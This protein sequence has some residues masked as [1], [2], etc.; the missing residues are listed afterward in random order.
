M[1][2]LFLEKTYGR[3]SHVGICDSRCE[4]VRSWDVLLRTLIILI[5]LLVMCD[6]MDSLIVTSSQILTIVG[7][8]IVQIV[9]ILHKTTKWRV[10]LIREEICLILMIRK[11]RWI[12]RRSRMKNIGNLII[13]RCLKCGKNWIG[14]L[15]L[16][17]LWSKY[18]SRRFIHIDHLHKTCHRFVQSLLER[19]NDRLKCLI[20]LLL[21]LLFDRLNWQRFIFV[22]NR[23]NL[24]YRSRS[25]WLKELDFFLFW[26]YINRDI[27]RGHFLILSRWSCFCTVFILIFYVG[28]GQFLLFCLINFCGF[29]RT[30]SKFNLLLE[31]DPSRTICFFLYR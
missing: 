25:S 4:I 14:L 29:C 31:L 23:S 15:N 30:G 17:I 10:C 6:L 20:Y 27:L 28:L 21:G 1:I 26:F 16:G 22:L 3:V 7:W 11:K 19:I 18:W 13:F 8:M 2:R 24:I 9:V 12:S 5:V